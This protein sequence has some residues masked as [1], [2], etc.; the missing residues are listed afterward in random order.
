MSGIVRA[1]N[2][3]FGV[4][5]RDLLLK[6]LDPSISRE[7]LE[8]ETSNLASRL[9]TMGTNERNAKLCQRGSERGHVTYFWNLGTPPYRKNGWSWKRQIWQAAS[10]TGILTKEMQN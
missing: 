2:V 4:T 7:R 9:S 10:S 5:T 6:F 3:K 8:L 1:G